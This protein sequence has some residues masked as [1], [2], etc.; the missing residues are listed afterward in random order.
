MID[1]GKPSVTK[2]EMDKTTMMPILLLLV[3][4]FLYALFWSYATIQRFD[5]GHSAIFDL[6]ISMQRIWN[7]YSTPQTPRSVLF[8]V[9]NYGTVFLL[10]PFSLFKNYAGLLTFQSIA[11]GVAAVPIYKISRYYL[12]DPWASLAISISYLLFFPLSGINWFDFH[13]QSLFIPF[14]LF[15]YYFYLREN[16]LTAIVFFALSGVT[17][18]PYIAFPALFSLYLLVQ[19]FYRRRS[20]DFIYGNKALWFAIF[21]FLISTVLFI[22]GYY[23]FSLTGSL[24]TELKISQNHN[25]EYLLKAK[26]LTVVLLLL[27]VLFLPIFS[28]KWFIFLLP[29]FFV[30]VYSNSW[31]FVYPSLFTLQYSSSIVPFIFLGTIDGLYTIQRRGNH[32]KAKRKKYIGRLKSFYSGEKLRPLTVIMLLA[33]ILFGLFFQPYGPANSVS[34]TNYYLTESTKVNT[35]LEYYINSELAMV[36]KYSTLLVQDNIPQAYP[37]PLNMSPQ[38]MYLVPGITNF[39]K[40]ISVQNA[41]MNRFPFIF[42]GKEYNTTIDFAI[43]DITDYLNENSLYSGSPNM[44]SFLNI[45]LSSHMYGIKA[46]EGG[47]MLLQRGFGNTPQNFVPYEHTFYLDKNSGSALFSENDI[48]R[49]VSK[50]VYNMSFKAPRYSGEY[51]GYYMTLLP[52]K[53]SFSVGFERTNLLGNATVMV[54]SVTST[55]KYLLFNE[56][57]SEGLLKSGNLSFFLEISNVQSNVYLTGIY[58]TSQPNNLISFVK[59]GQMN[60]AE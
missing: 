59:I 9:T 20:H 57:F 43:A 53:Y 13:F 21:L 3:A 29:F 48:V 25:I 10:V 15:G 2:R 4:V 19:F 18:F 30:M 44:I 37:R 11:L 47:V 24:G 38:S 55:G 1:S 60:F 26:I 8:E 7:V 6:G 31:T 45:L 52:G 42:N 32:G 17:K 54:D 33:I 41:L 35:T 50:G 36:P 22:L 51:P 16:Y 5:S 28:K 14:F 12:R 58:S 40:D 56:T 23:T 46:E 34:Q 27:P 39:C 49:E